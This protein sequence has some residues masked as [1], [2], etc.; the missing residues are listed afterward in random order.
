M[1]PVV[2]RWVSHCVGCHFDEAQKLY[3]V[4]LV[5]LGLG[6]SWDFLVVWYRVCGRE[7][8]DHSL[9]EDNKSRD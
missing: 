6:I 8:A 2:G 7:T 3:G 9:W 1:I 5:F 4:F